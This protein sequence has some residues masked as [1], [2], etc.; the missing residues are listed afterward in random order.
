MVARLG[1]R[2]STEKQNHPEPVVGGEHLLLQPHA[3]HFLI[4]IS[5]KTWRYSVLTCDRPVD[6]IFSCNFPS[7]L[8]WPNCTSRFRAH[9]HNLPKHSYFPPKLIYSP[10]FQLGKL[11]GRYVACIN[12]IFVASINDWMRNRRSM[13]IFC[14]ICIGWKGQVSV[15]LSIDSKGIAGGK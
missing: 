9:P 14:L 8:Q 7:I 4:Y 5:L 2:R 6:R 3:D 15:V 13:V 10:K 12:L 11:C 1:L